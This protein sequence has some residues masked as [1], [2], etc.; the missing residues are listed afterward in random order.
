MPL[1]GVGRVGSESFVT[2]Q[3]HS[4]RGTWPCMVR[5][6]MLELGIL[7]VVLSLECA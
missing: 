4:Q 6:A 5:Y 2:N 1:L 3:H 7:D